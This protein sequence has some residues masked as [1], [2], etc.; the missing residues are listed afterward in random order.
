MINAVAGEER[1]HEDP[2]DISS[3]GILS[4]LPLL[5]SR[6]LF[7]GASPAAEPVR[8]SSLLVL[9]IVP[10]LLLYAR[11]SFHLFEPDE[12]RYAEIPREMM[13]RGEWIIPYLQGEPYLDKPPLMYW[14]VGISY[15]FLGA[16]N[17]SARLIPA[18]AI[19]ACILLSYLFGRRILSERGA[20]WGALLLAVAPGFVTIG[21]LLVLDGLL[22][23]CIT[24][25]LL[26]AFE[27]IRRERLRLGWWLVS[28]AACGL[29]ILTKGPVALLLV[30]PPLW[31][32]RRFAGK[33]CI[34]KPSQALVYLGV[35]LG[36]SLPWYIAI[37]V[38]LPH[39]AY[40]FL[41]EHNVVRFLAPFD[42]L[43]PIWFYGPVLI[44]GLIPAVFF[45]I[46]FLRFLC[47]GRVEAG[48]RRPAELGFVLLAG[49]WCVAFFSL[50]GCKLPTYIMPAFPPLCLA[51]GFYVANSPWRETRWP[52]AVGLSGVL[53]M[54]LGHNLILPW[55][56]D[57]RA[58]VSHIAELREYCSDP[59]TPVI[60]YP[61]N[62]DSVAFYVCRDDLQSFRSKETHLLVYFLQQHPR[63][64]LLFAHRHSLDALKHALTPELEI[65]RQHHFGLAQLSGLP[66]GFA[67]KLNWLLGETSLGLCDV[68][69]IENRRLAG[70]S[71]AR[72]SLEN[73]PSRPLY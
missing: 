6:V 63:A 59:A 65:V 68:A 28:A 9:T 8:V 52:A 72:N 11:M 54:C 67:D 48:K 21:R 14:L 34:I 5:W 4:W 47:S 20:F 37:C 41:W 22:A 53:L 49:C 1:L 24:L 35:A 39:F 51:L 38:R 50:S 55:Y 64:V 16:Q 33:T 27:A 40:H 70:Q 2:S 58:P 30:L 7:P 42:H 69:L 62:V 25:S 45:L 57:Y 15:R 61:R 32:F 46:P 44:G 43:R 56:A 23:F 71:Q 31:L 66:K 19:H 26:A 36:L 3:R 18:L 29:G 60:C 17:W 12:G 13:V 73:L 10:A